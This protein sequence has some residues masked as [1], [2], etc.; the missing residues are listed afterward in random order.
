MRVVAVRVERGA[1]FAEFIRVDFAVMV[2]S[3]STLW[4]VNSIAPASC[5]FTCPVVAATTPAYGGVMASMTT[6]LV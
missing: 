4:P 6:W 3:V 2:G 1:V 5:T